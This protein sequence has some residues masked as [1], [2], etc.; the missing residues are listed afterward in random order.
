MLCLLCVE[1]RDEDHS[2]QPDQTARRATE[3]AAPAIERMPREETPERGHP[4]TVGPTLSAPPQDCAL[5]PQDLLKADGADL[6][7]HLGGLFDR[8]KLEDEYRA[9]GRLR[10]R[11]RPNPTAVRLGEPPGDG[12]P[13][14]TAGAGVRSALEGVEDPFPVGLGDPGTSIADA[15]E[16]PPATPEKDRES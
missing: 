8:G 5:G 3:P 14:A 13:E 16:N 15:D 1:Q 9:A 2:L 10:A 7:R 6:A 12:Q 4:K 11:L